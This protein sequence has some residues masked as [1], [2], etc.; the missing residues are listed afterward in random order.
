MSGVSLSI[1]E[2]RQDNQGIEHT[3]EILDKMRSGRPHRADD[4]GRWNLSNVSACVGSLPARTL[5]S[6][7]SICTLRPSD[8]MPGARDSGPR[9]SQPPIRVARHR[10]S[11]LRVPLGPGSPRPPFP[12]NLGDPPADPP[13]HLSECRRDA[14]YLRHATGRNPVAAVGR[15]LPAYLRL[16]HLFRDGYPP[17]RFSS[18]P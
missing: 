11:E 3:S 17:F 9:T 4:S 12:G 10:S 6:P 16:H 7:P 5:A 15:C 8:Q 2:G 14:G 13:D 1:P 18:S